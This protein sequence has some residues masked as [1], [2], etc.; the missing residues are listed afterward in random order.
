MKIFN[1]LTRKKEVFKPIKAGS[2]SLYT[3]GPTVYNFAHVGNLRTY[4]FQDIL[5]RWL[6]YRGFKVKH[7]MNV[8][9]VDDKTIRD[10]QKEGT[11]LKKFTK[12]YEDAF[13]EDLKSLNVIPADIIPRATEHISEMIKTIKILLE[14]GYAYKGEDGSIYFSIK[15]F[16][17]YG[18]L[19][20]LDLSELKSVS[21][22][23][24]DEY[25]KE[26]ARDFSLWKAWTPE[27]GDVFWETEIGKGR[28][29]WHIECSSMSSKYLGE[30]FDIHTGGVDLIFPHHTNE[31]AQSEAATGKPFVKY[32]MH[33]E[34]LLVD[35]KKMSKSLGNFYTLRDLL[36]KGHS[37]K[38]IRYL[39]LSTHYR[40]QLN[41]TEDSLKQAEKTVQNMIS[42]IDRIKDIKTKNKDNKEINELIEKRT[43]EFENNMD[44][45]LNVSLALASVF[46]LIRDVN[47]AIDE[48]NISQ[49]DLKKVYDAMM[50]FDKVLGILEHKKEKIPKE[51]LDL[52][53]K[54]EEARKKKDFKESDRIRDE[55]KKLGYIIE[56]SPVGPRIKKI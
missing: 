10:S 56:D 21:Q 49:K 39:F 1:T 11:S 25:S 50:N 48:D 18:K 22:M 42:F 20:G 35:G 6:L 32:W 19:A 26:D 23:N 31:I 27:D 45:D 33:G 14:K 24:K 12:K 5:K 29:G 44:D 28:P 47:K 43:K 51:V 34:H 36:K 30:T 52:V 9:D 37:A 4:V 8:T 17:D 55:I 46:E 3:C 38:A 15:K 41:L 54:R 13:F 53:K 2:V 40:T 7:V 16:K